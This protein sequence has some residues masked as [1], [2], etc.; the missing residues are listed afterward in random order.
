MPNFLSKQRRT[1][2][3]WIQTHK[4]AIFF[5]FARGLLILHLEKNSAGSVSDAT[6]NPSPQII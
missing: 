6:A 3:G 4:A 2:A 5:G 1:C